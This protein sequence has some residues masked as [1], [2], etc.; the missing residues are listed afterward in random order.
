MLP[1]VLPLCA[2]L[3][4]MALGS[5]A[6]AERTEGLHRLVATRLAARRAERSAQPADPGTGVPQTHAT[7]FAGDAIGCITLTRREMRSYGYPGH[8]FVCEEAAAGEVLGAVLDRNGRR[9]C[10]ITGG[11]AGDDCYD[12]AICGVSETLC[13]R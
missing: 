6:A 5:E 13:V 11:Y 3:L 7:D 9:R 4:T 10:L 12:L 8:A 1:F 2:A